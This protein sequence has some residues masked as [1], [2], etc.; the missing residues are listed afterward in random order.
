[1]QFEKVWIPKPLKQKDAIF[2]HIPFIGRPITLREIIYFVLALPIA[3]VLFFAG[4]SSMPIIPLIMFCISILIF[5]PLA[6]MLKVDGKYPEEILLGKL[7]YKK[8]ANSLLHEKAL[9]N[10]VSDSNTF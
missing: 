7:K 5:I 1:M 2:G 6:A 9:D 8:E 4:K 3:V 10:A